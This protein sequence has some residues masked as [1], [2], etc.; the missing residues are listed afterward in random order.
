MEIKGT[1]DFVEAWSSSMLRLAK[2][3]EDIIVIDADLGR[4]AGSYPFR[5]AFPNRYFNVGVSEQDM[6]C[7]ASGLAEAGKIPFVATFACFLIQRGCDQIINA[8][9]YNN[10]NVKMI[11][12]GA[13]LTCA[14]NGGTHMAI[15]DIA[16]TRSIPGMCVID[17]CDAVEFGKA[18]EFA[19]RIPG[20]VYIRSN[21]GKL[22]VFSD[23]GAEFSNKAVVMQNGSDVTLFTTGVTTSE[24]VTACK[25]LERLNIS[26]NHLHIPVIKPIDNNSIIQAAM[27]TQCVVTCENHNVLGGMGSA[28]AEVLSE[29]CPVPVYR[30]GIQD[31]FGE[32][33]DFDYLKEKYQID[34]TAITRKI[35]EVLKRESGIK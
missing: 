11:G 26:V 16:I 8:I 9:A 12:N 23:E 35:Q 24:G 6:L 34:S 31:A 29:A 17:P 5:D 14:K 10:S 19:A 33:A 22:P 3:N 7:F 28:I 27:K 4:A 2:S 25:T 18:L 13:G 21:R 1:A 32:T 30:L 15:S 20:P